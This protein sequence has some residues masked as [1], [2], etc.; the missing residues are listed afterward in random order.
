M[1]M[2]EINNIFQSKYERTKLEAMHGSV[3]KLVSTYMKTGIQIY[4]HQIV[5]ALAAL[6]DPLRKGFFG[7]AQFTMHNAQ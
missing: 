1:N 5:A 7:N 4:P 6:E 3:D 2:Q